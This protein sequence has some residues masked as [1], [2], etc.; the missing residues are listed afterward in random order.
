[1]KPEFYIASKISSGG[2]SGKQF[3]GPVIKVAISGIALG[4]IVMILSISIGQGFKKEIRE[5]LAGFGGHIQIVNY[6]YNLSFEAN[7][8]LEDSSLIH[9]L[10]SI[11]GVKSVQKI[12]TKPG[13]IKTGEEMQ[14]VILKGIGTDYD[15]TFLS[16]IL[17]KGKLPT[18]DGTST[19]EELLISN[20]LANM[21]SIDVG[22]QV[23]MYFFE[24]QIKM[25]KFHVS[26]IYD[27]SL[28][29]LDKLYVIADYRHVQKLNSWRPDQIAGYEIVIDD[30]DQMNTIGDKIYSQISTY[31]APDGALLRS[32]TIRQTQPQI[33]GWL[34]LLDMNIAVIIFLIIVVAGFN[35]ISGLLILILERTN[36]IGVLKSLGMA[37]WPLRRVFLVLAT[38]IAVRGLLI[39]NFIGI[40]IAVLQSKLGFIK[41]NPENY[42]LDVVPISLNP[43]DLILLNIG[44]TVAIFL[45]MIGPSYLAAKISP[46]KA[47][48]FD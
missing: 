41:L 25:R 24:K 39:G 44:A 33:F 28:P 1:M 8:I 3:A 35:M 6:D 40:T 42:F 15:E 23:M 9:S 31:I 12:A 46:V 27:S 5:K 14:G 19:T 17:K 34:D 45:M 21:L 36:M 7:P 38:R 48:L 32:Q 43:M 4:I 20:L 29:E 10:S 13:L 2:V 26:G 30:F 37:D 18:M 11:S 16:S 47:I 22:D